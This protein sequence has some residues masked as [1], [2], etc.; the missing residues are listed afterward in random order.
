[1]CVWIKI[2]ENLIKT[3]QKSVYCAA[4]IHIHTTHTCDIIFNSSFEAALKQKLGKKTKTTK[5]T[6]NNNI[7]DRKS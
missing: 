1:M 3:T 7:D 6:T 4:C 2:T 5:N